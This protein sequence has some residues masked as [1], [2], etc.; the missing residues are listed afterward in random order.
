MKSFA[1]RR[2]RNSILTIVVAVAV[3][4]YAWWSK[5]RL[6]RPEFATGYLLLSCLVFLAL[7]NT[8][9]KLPVL[10]WTTSA[11][12]LQT[13]IYVG[14]L[15]AV[16]FGIH[17]ACKIPSGYLEIALA[18]LY[19]LTF[20]SGLVGLYWTRSIPP[21][22]ARVSEEF[23]YERIPALRSQVQA[24]AEQTVLETVRATGS[25]TL[26]EF[27][28]QRVQGYLEKPRGL[29]YWFRPTSKVR[30][31][32]L[33]ELTEVSRYLSEPERNASETLFALI[34]RR[35][36]LDFHAA[37]QW[38]LKAWLFLHIGLT[39]PLLLVACL[40]GW[41]AHLFYGGAL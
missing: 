2:L 14:L 9:K 23:L 39:Y 32:L 12:W 17:V 20:A 22:L 1:S 38:R 37:M 30:K 33:A 8:R 29:D 11:G 15:T 10:A 5:A 26:G 34:R 18:A 25:D 35:D 4:W 36:D 13:H 28:A 31:R 19:L 24:R 7:Y 6:G 27:F 16:V 41:L 40:H 3:G 21:K